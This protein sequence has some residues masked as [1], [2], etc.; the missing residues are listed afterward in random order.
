MVE[1]EIYEDI[2]ELNKKIQQIPV[3]VEQMNTLVETIREM[4]KDMQDT[5]RLI[6]NITLMENAIK[7]IH[8]EITKIKNDVAEKI[9]EMSLKLENEKIERQKM[10][11]E[12][13]EPL[14]EQQSEINGA[15][16]VL[17]ILGL[18]V[19]AI[20]TVVTF[21]LPYLHKI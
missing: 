9:K 19:S 14:T 6:I 18:V 1:K 4:K 2:R 21:I 11:E 10:C 13:I 12:Q 15:V 5:N 20:W 8:E 16:K 7:N 3:L 17:K